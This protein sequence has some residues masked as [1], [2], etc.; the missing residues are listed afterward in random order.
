MAVDTLWRPVKYTMVPDSSNLLLRSRIDVK[1]DAGAKY[2]L[3]VDTLAMTSLYGQWNRPFTHEFSVKSPED[4]A[5]LK[6]KLPGIDSLNVIVELLNS[7][8]APV[9]R[10]INP[11][12]KPK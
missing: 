7:N 4:Y 1:W 12:E 9:Y 5:N 6:M 2:R 10:A 11:Q 3:T 8:D